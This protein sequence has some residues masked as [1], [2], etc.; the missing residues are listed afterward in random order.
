M[1]TSGGPGGGKDQFQAGTVFR[2]DT[3]GTFQHLYGFQGGFLGTPGSSP[4]GGLADGGDGFL[5]GTL[6]AGYGSVYRISLAGV[7]SYPF[8]FAGVGDGEGLS[9]LIGPLTEANGAIYGAA[10]SYG[11]VLFRLEGSVATIFHQFTGPDGSV[12]NGGLILGSDGDLYQPQGS[13]LIC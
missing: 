6:A 12:P 2:I 4:F 8:F 13:V 9:S 7:L 3:A 5:Y 1:T 10:T 11:G